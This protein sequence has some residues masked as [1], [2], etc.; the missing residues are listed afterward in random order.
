MK[1]GSYIIGACVCIQLVACSDGSPGSGVNDEVVTSQSKFLKSSHP[2]SG[3]YIV[4]LASTVSS[5]D[6]KATSES[7]TRRF[8]GQVIDVYEHALK[9]F[10]VRMTEA[11]AQALA[12]DPSVK[13]I[14][15]DSHSAITVTQANSAWGLDRIDQQTQP[16]NTTY[17]YIPQ[18]GAGV[19][20][21]VMDT[22]VRTTHSEFAGRIGN[23]A[24][25]VADGNDT[26]EDCHGHGTHVAATIAGTTYGVAKKAIIHPLRA[27]D[28]KGG[29][30]D[31][32][33]I[34]AV[35]WVYKNHQKPAV[36][37]MSL[38]TATLPALEDAIRASIA[39]GITYVIAAGNEGIDAC[40]KT[41]ARV[42]EAITVG[43]TTFSDYKASFSN[44]GPCLD[45][46][47]PGDGIR[48]AGIES[49]IDSA[50][51]SGT[52][53]AAPHVSGVA[54]LI[55]SQNSSATP[56]DVQKVLTESAT[57]GV[58]TVFNNP[59]PNLLLRAPTLPP[60]ACTVAISQTEAGADPAFTVE[61]NGPAS[62]ACTYEFDGVNM[63]P[64]ACSGTA[65]LKQ[66]PLGVHGLTLLPPN[67]NG[68]GE[69]SV[70]YRVRP[71]CLI[72]LS[73]TSGSIA[74][75][76]PITV[77]WKSTGNFCSYT[78]DG[79]NRGP[80]ACSG[81]ATL[82][83]RTFTQGTHT[84]GLFTAAEFGYYSQC[85]SPAFTITP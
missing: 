1:F 13:Y 62:D 72:E 75:N 73:S 23:G 56:A 44:D 18:A 33:V 77:T 80:I 36:V 58:V 26:V 39:N 57:K 81:T 52:S 63:G 45:L 76:T 31:S 22:G 53:M 83:A 37:N 20:V 50:V 35:D 82:E 30:P 70:S 65:V 61:W 60:P 7:L 64:V 54:A 59:S 85:T 46:F 68:T 74:A 15:E 17:S 10:S 29:G 16:L 12:K 41:P 32:M 79:K 38:Y 11:T 3:Q 25:F 67:Y 19:H 27:Q 71:S 78:Q 40:T 8:G 34:K 55:L 24:N 6:V 5:A 48:S 49:D 21:Y 14:Q 42:T 69:C 28:C 51:L 2:V 84:L 66:Q 43:A 9:G 47:A 4:V